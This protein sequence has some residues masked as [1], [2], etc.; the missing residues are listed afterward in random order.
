MDRA[1]K[2]AVMLRLE[3]NEKLAMMGK[4]H[5]LAD[6]FG[7][8]IGKASDAFSGVRTTFRRGRRQAEA[9]REANQKFYNAPDVK[10]YEVK[11]NRET[12]FVPKNELTRKELRKLKK[13][14]LYHNVLDEGAQ[15]KR[16]I[17]KQMADFD[18]SVRNPGQGTNTPTPPTAPKPKG[19]KKGK[20]DKSYFGSDDMY[21]HIG[22]G[23]AGVGLAGGGAYLLSRNKNNN[24]DQS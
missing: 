3:E 16:Y 18:A 9:T 6:Y 14:K 22:L 7:R 20:E 2:Q 10:V 19:K 23:T 5:H 24:D 21:R 11:R 8:G 12:T 4:I 15:K 17:D 1:K 13:G